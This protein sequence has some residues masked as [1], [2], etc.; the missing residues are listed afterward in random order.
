MV[1]PTPSRVRVA[2][3]RAR[4]ISSTGWRKNSGEK[5][6]FIES[7]TGPL[8]HGQGGLAARR[9]EGRIELC[10]LVSRQNQGES[11]MVFDRV[12]GRTSLGYGDDVAAAQ[13]PGERDLERRGAALGGDLRQRAGHL[14]P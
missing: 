13:D 4:A 11:P 5:R 2:P 8:E 9:R 14:E 12:G 1:P 3:M 10:Q 7:G 6:S